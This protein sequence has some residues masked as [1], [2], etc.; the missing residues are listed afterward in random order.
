MG[1]LVAEQM[2]Q[3][4]FDE[5]TPVIERAG[6]I[7]TNTGGDIDKVT[8]YLSKMGYK[9]NVQDLEREMNDARAN[10][11]SALRSEISEQEALAESIGSAVKS[12]K[13]YRESLNTGSASA[14]SLDQQQSDLMLRQTLLA[15]QAGAGDVDAVG[16]LINVSS[17]YLAVTKDM[18]HNETEYAREVSRT[19][20]LMSDVELDLV[21][22]QTEAEKQTEWLQKIYESVSGESLTEINWRDARRSYREALRAY[23]T[24]GGEGFATGGSFMVGGS[25]SIDSLSLPDLRV[26]PGEMVNISRPDVMSSMSEELAALRAEVKLL[27]KENQVHAV[28]QIKSTQRIERNTDYLESWDVNGLPAEETA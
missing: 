3:E 7:W 14:L 23:N 16:D 27:R 6:R 20:N 17:E 18:A 25:G 8:K 2:A 21:A 28:A 26:S 15:G 4:M 12:I 24:A 19:A 5:I 22:Q 13:E 1:N 9:T 11:I 10:Y